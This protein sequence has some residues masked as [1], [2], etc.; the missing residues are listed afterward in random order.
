MDLIFFRKRGS[1][2]KKMRQ[3]GYYPVVWL[4]NNENIQIAS[5]ND[6]WMNKTYHVHRKT[7]Y[8]DIFILWAQGIFEKQSDAINFACKINDMP[9]IAF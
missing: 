6:A 3:V 2:K 7:L 8:G 9:L 5:C 1:K 4:S